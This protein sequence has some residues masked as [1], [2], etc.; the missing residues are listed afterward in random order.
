MLPIRE[1]LWDDWNEAHIARHGVAVE[2]VEDV[3]WGHSLGVRIRRGRYR[4]IGQT[5][6]ER[7]LTVILA[8]ERGREFYVLT[9]RDATQRERGRLRSWRGR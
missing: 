8:Y 4:I 3:C 1:L 9:A 2:E 5:S 7:Y 6:A